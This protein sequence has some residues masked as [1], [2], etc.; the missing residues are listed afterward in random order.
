[1]DFLSKVMNE[2]Q[3][4]DEHLTVKECYDALQK[5][6]SSKSPGNDGL[7]K[8]FYCTFWDKLGPLLLECLNDSFEK[9]CL[10]ISQRQAVITVIEKPGKDVRY[11]KNWRPISLI[12]VDVKICNSLIG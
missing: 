1:M 7:T 4:C 3:N 10:T 9:G 12:N 6:G 11:L 8:E 5:L 2:S